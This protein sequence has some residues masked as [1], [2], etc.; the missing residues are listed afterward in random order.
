MWYRRP[1]GWRRESHRHSL[2]ARGIRTRFFA[3]KDFDPIRALIEREEREFQEAE[4][5]KKAAE[6]IIRGELTLEEKAIEEAKKKQ[7]EME[8]A[9][10]HAASEAYRKKREKAKKEKEA[11]E[12]ALGENMVIAEGPMEYG[13][14]ALPAQGAP[15]FLIKKGAVTG[16]QP[17]SHTTEA[18]KAE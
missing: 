10:S 12:A 5:R 1:V 11:A 13:G 17:W 4:E 16:Y 2:A 14:R 15:N 9:R 3:D 7:V 6:R 18:A 8:I